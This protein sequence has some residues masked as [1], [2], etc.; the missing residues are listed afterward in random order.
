MMT[1]KLLIVFSNTS[2]HFK[3]VNKY[4]KRLRVKRML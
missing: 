4:R 3:I 2:K 1:V